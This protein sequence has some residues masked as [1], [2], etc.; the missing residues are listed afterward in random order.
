M[1][2]C[3]GCAR[4]PLRFLVYLYPRMSYRECFMAILY[5][6]EFDCEKFCKPTRLLQLR[7]TQSETDVLLLTEPRLLC[8]CA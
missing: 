8:V 1:S 7:E 2:V 5:A 6:P 4:M 3:I